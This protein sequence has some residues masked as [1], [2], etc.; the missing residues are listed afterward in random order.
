MNQAAPKKKYGLFAL[1]ILLLLLGALTCFL[2]SKSFVIR[3]LGLM[4]CMASVYL[5]R[6][7]NVHKTRSLSVETAGVV[8]GE[9]IKRRPGRLLWTLAGALALLWVASLL[10]LYLDTL[11]GDHD[12]QPIYLFAA[13]SLAGTIV[14][15]YLITKILWV[16]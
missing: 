2:G 4:A 15:P 13:V 9:R 14:W 1:A 11:H 10:Y 3:S 6:A 16:K 5:V 12:V 8:E 7:S